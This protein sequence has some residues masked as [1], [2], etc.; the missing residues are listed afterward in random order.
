M[1]V[2]ITRNSSPEQYVGKKKDW[3]C[4]FSSW[5]YEMKT[6]AYTDSLVIQIYRLS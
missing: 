2:G 3:V 6:L 4:L 5:S 1:S